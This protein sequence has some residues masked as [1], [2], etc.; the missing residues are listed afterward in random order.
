[1]TSH[2]EAL[3]DIQLVGQ[4][5]MVGFEGKTVDPDLEALITRFCVGGIALFKRNISGPEQ[6]S[7]LWRQAQSLFK[8]NNKPLL[9]IQLH[10]EGR[11]ET[12]QGTTFTFFTGNRAIGAS[13]SEAAAEEFA[14]TTAKELQGVGI[15]MNFAPVLD[16]VPFDDDTFV[17]TNRVFGDSPRLTADLGTKV[18]EAMQSSGLAA[19]GKHFPG[20]GR[21]TLDSHADLPFLETKEETLRTSDLIPFRAAIEH[22]VAAIMLAHVIYTD[23]DPEWPASLSGRLANNLLRHTMGFAGV[24]ITDDLDMGAVSKHYGIRTIAERICDAQVDVALLCRS[25]PEVVKIAHEHLME[26][27]HGSDHARAAH[28]NS[29]E[30]ILALKDRYIAKV[31]FGSP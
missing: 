20:I 8:Q 23:I 3:S 9:L 13:E 15:N 2:T 18:I 4:R 7:T 30:R 19:T 1:M 6:S 28:L 10:Q 21:T 5:L 26:T 25:G 31:A 29:V 27:V 24:T 11:P 17:M 22:G 16:T 12:R 14:V